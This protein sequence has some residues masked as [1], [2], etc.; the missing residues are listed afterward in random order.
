MGFEWRFFD[1]VELFLDERPFVRNTDSVD[2]FD[3][4]IVL[5]EAFPNVFGRFHSKTVVSADFLHL[6]APVEALG[7]AVLA[8]EFE[9]AYSLSLG[10]LDHRLDKLGTYAASREFWQSPE[11]KDVASPAVFD[12]AKLTGRPV[13]LNVGHADDMPVNKRDQLCGLVG[14]VV[15]AF[16]DG[17]VP[18][19][20]GAEND[21]MHAHPFAAIFGAVFA[22]NEIHRSISVEAA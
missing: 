9:A 18:G 22:N 1:D 19:V 14:F 3:A 21:G 16:L 10:V 4:D 8:P 20:G 7:S 11:F 15:W 6:H 17:V 2:V 12:V 5:A 13:V